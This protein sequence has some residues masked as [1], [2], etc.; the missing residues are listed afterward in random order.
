MLRNTF[1][2]FSVNGFTNLQ[3]GGARSHSAGFTFKLFNRSVSSNTLA[4][5][6]DFATADRGTD[7]PAEFTLGESTGLRGYAA[8]QFSGTNRLR[9]NF[10]DR[11]FTGWR[12]GAFDIGLL[13]FVDAG[14]AGDDIDELSLSSSAGIGLRLGSNALM[15]RNVTRLDLAYPFN[16]VD[17]DSS[18]S[19][20]IATGQ[21][22]TF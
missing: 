7:L 2:S 5:R 6:V 9:L 14:W 21:V 8:R 20:S 22:F 4:A 11:I 16:P 12:I 3:S 1:G 17:G 10:E 19:L 13:A 18:L 15:G